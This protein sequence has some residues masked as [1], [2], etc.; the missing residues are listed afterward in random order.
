MNCPKCKKEAVEGAPFCPWCGAKLIAPQR[1][2]KPKTRGN[3]QGT[4]YKRG[5]HWCALWRHY[6]GGECLRIYKGG[7]ETKSAALDFLAHI[8]DAPREDPNI[9]LAALYDKWISRHAERVGRSTINCYKAAW[10]YFEPLRLFPFVH[11]TTDLWQSCVDECPHG[12]RTRENMKALATS[13][14]KYA[15]ELGIASEDYGQHIYI[16][17]GEKR[18]KRAFTAAELAVMFNAA[19]TVPFVDVILIYCYTGFRPNELLA[20]EPSAFDPNEKTLRGGGKT[21]AGRDRIVTVSPKILPFVLARYNEHDPRLICEDGKRITTNHW[22]D[23]QRRAL[24]ALPCIRDLTPHECRH[25]F[26][27]LMKRVEASKEDKKRLIGHASDAMLEHYTH[28]EIE[29]LRAIT[30]A[31]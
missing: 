25:T 28:A 30:D 3:G 13:L 12:E 21:E 15:H 4:A 2:Q 8:K 31:L 19:G 7:F 23:L 20:M 27:T 5:K 1:K 18:E 26:A 10:K 16:K 9:T 14:F 11:I 17:R 24:N 6:Y 22:S 29:E